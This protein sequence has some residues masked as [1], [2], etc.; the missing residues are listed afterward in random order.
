MVLLLLKAHILEVAQIKPT[1]FKC[2]RSETNSNVLVLKIN[3][4]TKT[5]KLTDSYHLKEKHKIWKAE[6]KLRSFPLFACFSNTNAFNAGRTQ[7]TLI[8][9]HLL[10][11]ET[12][13]IL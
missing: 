10:A 7:K 1:I 13:D 9:N 6:V 8:D 11:F 5:V 2:A 3:L 4:I 12:D